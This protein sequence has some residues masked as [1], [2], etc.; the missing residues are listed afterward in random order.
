MLRLSSSLH[1][2]VARVRAA[3]AHRHAEALRRAHDDVGAPL[4][5]GPEQREREQVGGGDHEAA[6][7][8]HG[9]GERRGS[10]APR[11]RRRGTAPAPRTPP[12]PRAAPRAS[13]APRCPAARRACAPRRSSAAAR[14]RRRRT[15]SP[16]AFAERCAQ[17]HRLGRGGGLV[18]HRR[19]GDGHAGEVGD[20]RLEVEQR[21]EAALRDLRLVGRVGRVPGG[22]LEHVAQDHAGRVGAV[23]ALADVRLAAPGSSRR[24]GASRRAPRPRSSRGAASSAPC[25]GSRRGT[26]ASISASSE[27]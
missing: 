14:R 19:V 10:R 1:R 3:E 9:R 6:L 2:H 20:H 17:R 26:T 5:R 7:R 25:G 16:R 21:L 27:P 23:V 24:G 4:A 15:P 11:R 13:P 8:V 22:V 12:R 18:E